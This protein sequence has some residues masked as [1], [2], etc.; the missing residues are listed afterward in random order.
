M[1]ESNRQ[2]EYPLGVNQQELK[3]LQFQ[4]TVWG[5]ITRKFLVY[6]FGSRRPEGG[7]PYLTARLPAIFR[8]HGLRLIDFTPTCLAGEPASGITEWA[9][10]FFSGHMQTMVNKGVI[11]QQAADDAQIDWNRHREDPDSIFFSPL[12]VDVA[13]TLPM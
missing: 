6:L 7:D 10:Q 2:R 9:H 1:P 13:A 11:S 3:R 4:R 12:V 8:K 5:P